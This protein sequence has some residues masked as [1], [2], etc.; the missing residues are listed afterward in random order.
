M[1]ET[2]TAWLITEALNETQTKVTWGLRGKTPFPGN[3]ICLVMNVRQKLA[4]DFDDGLAMLKK[5]LE[6]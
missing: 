6:Q 3:V 5:H 1:Q 4:A 2:N